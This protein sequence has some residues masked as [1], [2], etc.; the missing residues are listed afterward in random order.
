M[1]R[2]EE[3]YRHFCQQF[4]AKSLELYCKNIPFKTLSSMK[5]LLSRLDLRKLNSLRGCVSSVP[6]KCSLDHF[7]SE[8]PSDSLC[9]L[10]S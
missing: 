5:D 7:R 8:V 3:G 10:K 1:Q 6:C 4:T 9:M 2:Q